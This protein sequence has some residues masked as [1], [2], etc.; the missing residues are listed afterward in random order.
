MLHEVF[1][2]KTNSVLTG[3]NVLD[4][5]DSNMDGFLQEIYVFLQLS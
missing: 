4:T 5:A 1:L 3:N 2:T